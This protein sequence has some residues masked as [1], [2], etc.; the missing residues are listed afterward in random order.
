MSDEH[1]VPA[2]QGAAVAKALNG[3]RSRDID[4]WQDY[5]RK[6]AAKLAKDPAAPEGAVK[7]LAGLARDGGPAEDPAD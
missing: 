1:D 7:P 2:T 6:E 4:R 5:S 3:D